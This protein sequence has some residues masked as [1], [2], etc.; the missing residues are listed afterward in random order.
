MIENKKTEERYYTSDPS[1]MVGKYITQRVYR[2]YIQELI[3]KDSGKVE[4]I[5]RHEILF[6]RGILITPDVLEEIKFWINEGS[7]KEIEVSNQKRLSFTQE[8]TYMFPYRTMAKID[9]KKHSFLLYALSVQNVIE[10][11][12]DFIELNYSGGFTITDIKELDYCVVLVDKLKSIKQR[13]LELDIAYLNDE[14]TM[15]EYMYSKIDNKSENENA[16]IEDDS[17]DLKLKFY[18]IGAK[19]ISRIDENDTN[20][21]EYSQTFIVQTFSAVRAN[22]IIE[23]FLQDQ[24]EKLYIE[25][26]S[27]PDR[28]FIKKQIMS[29]IE[30]SKIISIGRFIPKIFSEAYNVE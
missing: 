13:N 28:N 14:I 3:D 16:N 10:I 5:E 29:F 4:S 27:H 7:I 21:E 8:N 15:E 2:T 26:L 1:R 19:I 20:E 23:K 6:D 30:E 12:T 24:Q 9:G 17:D 18:Q 22:L 11:I 25:S